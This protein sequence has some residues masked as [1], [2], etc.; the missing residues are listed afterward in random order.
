M[1]GFR[2]LPYGEPDNDW[3]SIDSDYTKRSKALSYLGDV[4][5]AGNPVDADEGLSFLRKDAY[6]GA[7]FLTVE[8]SRTLQMLVNRE[9]FVPT[10]G[11]DALVD[12]LRTAVY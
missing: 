1:E 12:I 4:P 3:P 8:K 11:L 6:L 10:A 9:G 2:V 7:V 5:Q